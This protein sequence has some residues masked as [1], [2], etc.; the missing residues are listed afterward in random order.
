MPNW[1]LVLR[2]N[3]SYMPYFPSLPCFYFMHCMFLLLDHF[4]LDI[5]QC[6]TSFL[7]FFSVTFVLIEYHYLCA[8]SACCKPLS[9][10]KIQC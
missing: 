7:F 2:N 9:T 6:A 1:P 8:L 10:I 4:E 3:P 5:C